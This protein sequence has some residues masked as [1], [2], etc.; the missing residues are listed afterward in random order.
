MAGRTA[1]ANFSDI[2]A[3]SSE[4]TAPTVHYGR[5]PRLEAYTARVVVSSGEPTAS[6]SRIECRA[7][8]DADPEAEA[9]VLA[10][11][12]AFVL[13]CHEQKVA[14]AGSSD[15]N[16]TEGGHMGRSPEAHPTRG[17]SA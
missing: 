15:E 5:R 9:R 6:E 10:A 14:A 11:V 3:S 16:I 7:R 8:P 4:D 1:W 2:G 17:G 12:Y 13:R